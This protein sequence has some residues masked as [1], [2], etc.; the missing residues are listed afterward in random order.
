MQNMNEMMEYFEMEEGTNVKEFLFRLLSKWYWFVLFGFLGLSGGYLISKF[1]PP[2]YKIGSTVLVQEDS[3][4][5]GLDQLFEGFDLG[6]KTNIENHILMLK[7]Y[8]LNRQA[9]E[10]LHREISWFYPKVITDVGLYGNYPYELEKYSLDK[11]LIGVPVYIVPLDEQ[12]YQVKVRGDFM[13]HGASL[14][15]DMTAKGTYGLPFENDYFSFTLNRNLGFSVPLEESYYFVFNDL[16]GLAKSYSSKLEVNLASKKADGISLSIQGNNSARE[17][18]YLNELIRVYMDYGLSEKNRTSKNTVRFIDLQ[19]GQIVDSL[20]LAGQNFSDFRSQNGII[21][22]GQ[23]SGLVV[24][25]LE[26]LESEKALAER[27]LDYYRNLKAYM[28]DAEQMKLIAS[29][30]VVGI[31]DAGLNAQVLKLAELY[32]RKS[33][34]TFIAREK[35]PSVLMVNNEIANTL[36]SLD[37]NL[38]NLLSNSEVELKSLSRRLDQINAELASLP[39][40]EQKL[41]N[42]K[43]RFDLNNELYTFLLQKRAEAA[44]TMASNVSDAQVLDPASIDTSVKVGPKT[45]INLLIGLILGLAIPFLLIVVGDYFNDTIQSKDD[46]EKD[47]KLP[48]MAEISRNSYDSEIPVVL[49]PRSGIAESFRGLRTN[50]QY[51]FSETKGCKVLS[52]HS[53]LPGEGKTFTSIN[54]SSILAM[55]NKKVLLL[56]CD[57]RKPRL[58]TIFGVDNKIGLSTYLIRKNDYRSIIQPTN[59]QNMFFVNAGPVPPNPSEL[60]GNREM[61]KFIEEAK[62]EFDYIVMDNAPVTLVTDGILT[63]KHADANLFV[64]RQGFSSK[65]QIKF[66]NQLNDSKNLN[67]IG[68]VLNDTVFT[69][70]RFNT[71]GKF[72]YGNSYGSYAYG[73]C[74]YED[75]RPQQNWKQKLF[76]KFSKN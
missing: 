2:T 49:H 75:D 14:E 72:G 28:G 11:N 1:S 6:S 16:K 42:I 27:R 4:G 64:L 5:M 31:V 54:L 39:K 21:D 30:S 26:K 74:Y 8:T 44:I 10:N 12:H 69:S 34:L 29:P 73:N 37:E 61:A 71:Y 3:K 47:S 40:T 68:V 58:H 9:L 45:T 36:A 25:K 76:S 22:L 55:D 67:Q 15:L 48:V 7:S 66:I 24:E 23:E 43:R 32:S 46:I 60:L 51:L 53:M 18:D 50:L 17:V 59:L 62:K 38:K 41:I 65:D 56:G 33:S 19:L 63:G 20:S 13:I 52:V 70:Y 35:N 57:L